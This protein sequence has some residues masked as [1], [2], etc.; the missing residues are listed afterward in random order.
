MA[1]SKKRVAKT[2]KAVAENNGEKKAKKAVRG[3][4]DLLRDAVRKVGSEALFAEAVGA[5]QQSVSAWLNGTNAP[6]AAMQTKLK[7]LYN[8]PEPW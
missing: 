2:E 1:S 6:R 8:I 3:Q 5:S 7:K 4:P